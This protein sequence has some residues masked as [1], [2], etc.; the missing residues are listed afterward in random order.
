MYLLLVLLFS[1]AFGSAQEEYVPWTKGGNIIKTENAD[2][3][4][5]TGPK[6]APGYKG[7]I[8]TKFVVYR[9]DSHSDPNQSRIFTND[10]EQFLSWINKKQV[11]QCCQYRGSLLVSAIGLAERKLGVTSTT[12]LQVLDNPGYCLTSQVRTCSPKHVQSVEWRI[13]A[14]RALHEKYK[15]ISY[16]GSTNSQLGNLTNENFARRFWIGPDIKLSNKKDKQC[17]VLHS[18]M[19]GGRNEPCLGRLRSLLKKLGVQNVKSEI[20][21]PEANWG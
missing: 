7:Y 17:N 16:Q 20:P 12:D 14:L 21:E 8:T 5:L 18:T 19:G 1:F 4:W 9:P 15:L 3:S 13:L 6:D 2:L 11:L 10:Q